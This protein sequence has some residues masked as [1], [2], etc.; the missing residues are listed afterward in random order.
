MP[1]S[2]TTRHAL[3]LSK[4]GGLGSALIAPLITDTR[5]SP[6]AHLNLIL[7]RILAQGTRI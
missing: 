4:I 3:D 2:I 1:P 5:V 6:L 7:I